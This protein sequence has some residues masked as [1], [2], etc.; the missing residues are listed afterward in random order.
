[1]LVPAFAVAKVVDTT[2]AGDAFNGAF[3]AA[4]AEGRDPVEATRFACA[5]AAISVG[6]P[7]TAASMPNRGEIDALMQN[8]LA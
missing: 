2:G 7:G 6:R 1:V 3:A 8:A 4:L 5:A